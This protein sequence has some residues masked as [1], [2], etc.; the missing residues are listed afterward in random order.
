MMK[1]M[2]VLSSQGNSLQAYLKVGP[3]MTGTF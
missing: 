1:E 3:I 2:F